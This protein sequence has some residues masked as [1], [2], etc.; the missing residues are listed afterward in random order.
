MLLVVALPVC[1]ASFPSQQ[2]VSLAKEW[3]IKFSQPVDAN[4]LQNNIVITRIDIVHIIAEIFPITPVLDPSDPK[5]VIIKHSTPFIAGATYDL[6]VN[7]G[8]KDTSGKVLAKASSLSFVTKGIPT[9]Q[10]SGTGTKATSQFKLTKGLSVVTSSY[11][12][13]LIL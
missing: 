10:L 5:V 6:S 12:G 13:I 9:L 11:I 8:I 7:V 2:N 4:T 3:K 1:A